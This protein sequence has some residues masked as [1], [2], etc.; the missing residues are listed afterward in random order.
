MNKTIWGNGFQL[1]PA[2]MEFLQNEFTGAIGG[3]VGDISSYVVSGCN[4][5]GG[6]RTNG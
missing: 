4:V 5:V 1:T 3:V 6:V 2:A